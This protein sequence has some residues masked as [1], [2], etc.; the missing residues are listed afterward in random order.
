MPK[1]S[2]ALASLNGLTQ[3]ILAGIVGAAL[4]VLLIVIW[5]HITGK[6]DN[7]Y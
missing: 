2:T 4:T 5:A 1:L 6:K 7:Y 3:Y